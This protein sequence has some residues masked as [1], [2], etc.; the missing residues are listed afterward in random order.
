MPH[1][2]PQLRCTFLNAVAMI[3]ATVDEPAIRDFQNSQLTVTIDGCQICQ[4]ILQ[5][6]WAVPSTVETS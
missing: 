5:N 3:A 4:K 2:I 6:V 1:N